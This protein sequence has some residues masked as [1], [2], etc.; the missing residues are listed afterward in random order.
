MQEHSFIFT[1]QVEFVG[2][3]VKRLF[4]ALKLTKSATTHCSITQQTASLY[5]FL[6]IYLYVGL[7][8]LLFRPRVIT[9][10]VTMVPQVLQQPRASTSYT[11]RGRQRVQPR[12]CLHAGA[13]GAEAP[14]IVEVC[15]LATANVCRAHLLLEKVSKPE[16][17]QAG[18]IT[19]IWPL[20]K[21]KLTQRLGR[22]PMKV[23]FSW[24][25]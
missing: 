24:N 1:Y 5:P 13:D 25:M 17:N 8:Y 20:A 19:S 6:R 22:V 23:N 16:Q 15:P 7:S 18:S 9:H 3:E 4:Y 2:Q 14:G 21:N 11:L 12:C 10:C